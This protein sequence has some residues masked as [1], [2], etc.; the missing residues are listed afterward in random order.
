MN[1]GIFIVYYEGYNDSS[2]HSAPFEGGH[3][4]FLNVEKDEKVYLNKK[5]P[6]LTEPNMSNN[7][8][9]LFMRTYQ[10][11][12][13]LSCVF[14]NYAEDLKYEVCCNID[15]N[16]DFRRIQLVVPYDDSTLVVAKDNLLYLMSL[17]DD[18]IHLKLRM[19]NSYI[20]DIKISPDKKIIALACKSSINGTERR[21]TFCFYD[22]TTDN[23]MF[24]NIN[25]IGF[26][27]WSPDQKNI[28]II[29]STENSTINIWSYPSLVSH[30]IPSYVIGGHYAW[31]GKF[32]SNDTI[33][34][35]AS[36]DRRECY[37][38][39]YYLFSISER[40]MIRQLTNDENIKWVP[41]IF[42]N[43]VLLY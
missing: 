9:A 30:K 39:N 37:K 6:L 20:D 42:S 31:M 14:Y 3:L 8:R 28:I 38:L 17:R 25:G 15:S 5:I 40:K 7:G 2:S 23:L 34:V 19:K 32:I 43:G 41:Q 4:C 18:S 29:D 21:L 12:N 36:K 27:N 24:A 22:L 33:V 11:L 10:K 13:K 26:G 16:A 1:R 35:L